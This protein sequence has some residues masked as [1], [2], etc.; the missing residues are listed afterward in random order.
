[1][2]LLSN[3]TLCDSQTLHPTNGRSAIPSAEI[4]CLKVG[5]VLF[6]GHSMGITETP[7]VTR[8]SRVTGLLYAYKS[9]DTPTLVMNDLV[10][11]RCSWV[12]RLLVQYN[13]LNT[14]LR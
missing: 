10:G 7:I 4:G 2:N 5:S 11:T 3:L 12:L 8:H 14:P 1:M 9:S 6:G 13:S